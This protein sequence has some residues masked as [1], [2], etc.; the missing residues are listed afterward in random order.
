MDIKIL[1]SLILILLFSVSVFAI[2]TNIQ[3]QLSST[4]VW[5]NDS[6]KINGTANFSNGT[7]ISD[8][9]INIT[10]GTVKCNNVTDSNGIWE[11]TFL[12]PLELGTYDVII[13]ITK[14]DVYTNRTTL[15]VAPK[16]GET[17]I[18][19]GSRVVYE[20]QL[21]IQEPSGNITRAWARVTVWR[22]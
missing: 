11:C 3:S 14:T 19:K 17:P 9:V 13:N 5:W 18:G 10:V 8:A 1:L 4:Q 15:K 22:G 20:A 2:G 16:Y 6:V 12:A 7:A 21:P